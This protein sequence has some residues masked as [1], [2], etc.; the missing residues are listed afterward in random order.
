MLRGLDYKIPTGRA[1]A[2]A[3]SPGWFVRQ[4]R[5]EFSGEMKKRKL[6]G[7]IFDRD[8]VRD[9]ITIETRRERRTQLRIRI[10]EQGLR[11][12]SDSNESVDFSFRAHNTGRQR[13]SWRLLCGRR[14]SPAR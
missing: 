2:L 6:R 8:I 10:E 5:R 4:G 3:A 9:E 1:E 14:S 11:L 7:Y 13:K 12:R